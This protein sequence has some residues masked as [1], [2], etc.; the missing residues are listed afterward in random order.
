M[1]EKDDNNNNSEGE[2]PLINRKRFWLIMGCLVA[3]L[4]IVSW[5]KFDARTDVTQQI[6]QLKISTQ[7]TKQ[8]IERNS[9]EINQTAAAVG[10]LSHNVKIAVQNQKTLA[11]GL[12]NV[13]SV[14][15][16]IANDTGLIP[17]IK[18]DTSKVLKQ[19]N[20]LFNIT[21]ANKTIPFVE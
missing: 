16:E 4:I 15:S 11:K 19:T 8:E 9:G 14:V 20:K 2:K 18:V 13:G 21:I 10:N 5:I 3:V 7:Q 12:S 17:E 6:S 1:S